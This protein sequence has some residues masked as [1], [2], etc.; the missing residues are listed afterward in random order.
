[1]HPLQR[2]CARAAG[3]STHSAYRGHNYRFR[4]HHRVN[5][6][7]ENGVEFWHQDR[8]GPTH[9]RQQL[10]CTGIASTR[11]EGKIHDYPA[12]VPNQ[13]FLVI[14][15][16]R[17]SGVFSISASRRR[18]MLSNSVVTIWDI[19]LVGD[20]DELLFD[21]L[22]LR[23][24]HLGDPFLQQQAHLNWLNGPSVAA[25]KQTV[26][27]GYSS[28]L[29]FAPL[30]ISTSVRTAISLCSRANACRLY[31]LFGLPDGLPLWPGCQ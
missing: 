21:L 8:E 11:R 17:T 27:C 29:R 1:L 15:M 26:R 7:C 28:R 23:R 9:I 24:R 25:I 10:A 30:P 5:S 22:Q 18:T 12:I 6:V 3:F 14:L 31:T 4:K 16:P 19:L 13:K 2:L 20:C